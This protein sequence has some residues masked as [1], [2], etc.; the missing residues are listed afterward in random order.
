LIS[1]GLIR[2][3]LIEACVRFHPHVAKAPAVVQI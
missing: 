2:E 3:V 1:S